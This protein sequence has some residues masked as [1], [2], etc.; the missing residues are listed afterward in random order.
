MKVLIIDNYDSFTFNLF[1]YCGEILD[2]NT[3]AGYTEFQVPHIVNS[4]SAFATGQLPDKDGQM[5]H[6]NN[7]NLYLIPTSEVPLTNIYRNKIINENALPIK[8]TSYTPCFRREA[9]SYGSH[10]RGLN[11]LCLLYTSDA[12]DE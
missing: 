1:Q 4:D 2:K 5:Y 6:V 8:M 7:E 11:R 3:S 12:A 9:G 10:V